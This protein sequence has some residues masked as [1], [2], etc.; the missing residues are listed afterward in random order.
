[1]LGGGIGCNL[2]MAVTQSF[3]GESCVIMGMVVTQSVRRRESGVIMGMAV[4]KSPRGR[5]PDVIMGMA[6]TQSGRAHIDKVRS[7]PGLLGV[8]AGYYSVR[9]YKI[10]S[11]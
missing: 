9:M 11:R 3:R 6:G 4:T 8:M 10:G 5:T 2:G 7:A 1:M